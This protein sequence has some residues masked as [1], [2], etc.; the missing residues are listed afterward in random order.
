MKRGSKKQAGESEKFTAAQKKR[1]LG[2]TKEL[3]TQLEDCKEELKGTIM[4]HIRF[5]PHG[6][7]KKQAPKG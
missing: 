1:L 4:Q 2:L 7:P 5:K 3:E 6:P